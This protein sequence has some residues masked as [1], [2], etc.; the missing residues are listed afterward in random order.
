[1]LP[2]NDHHSRD[3]QPV[4]SKACCIFVC[5]WLQ[6]EKLHNSCEDSQ[7]SH[8]VNMVLVSMV[9]IVRTK[10]VEDGE[11]CSKKI[12]KDRLMECIVYDKW[13]K[14]GCQTHLVV[15]SMVTGSFKSGGAPF[16]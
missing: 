6:Q 13:M 8:L 14:F 5:L 3:L 7:P 1:M 9:G 15:L 12:G 16:Y 2:S 10:V 4:Q 11:K